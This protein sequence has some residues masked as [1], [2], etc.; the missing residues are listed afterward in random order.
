MRSNK[1]TAALIAAAASLTLSFAAASAASARVPHL[2]AN[3][4]RA[5]GCRVTLDFAYRVIEANQPATAVGN[6]ICANPSEETG[7][8]V[9]LYQRA[10]NTAKTSTYTVAGTGTTE[11]GGA[12]SIE[13]KGVTT[14][15]IFYALAGGIASR[16]RPLGVTAEVKVEGPPEGVIFTGPLAR[17]HRKVTATFKGTVSPLDEGAHVILQRQNALNGNGWLSINRPAIVNGKGEYTIEHEFVIPGPANIRVLVRDPKVNLPS[18]SNVLSYEVS[19][20]EN[21]QF[22]IESKADPISYGQSVTIGGA[23]S[24][25]PV[26]TPVKLLARAANQNHFAVVAEGKTEDSTGTYTV[27]SQTPLVNTYYKAEAAGKHSTILFEGVK[28]VLTAALLPGTSVSKGTELTFSG[29]VKPGV[30]KHIV[31]LEREDASHTAFNVVET[32]EVHEPNAE[33]PEYWYS[34]KYTPELVG[35]SKFRVKIP[36]DPQNG[37]TESETFTVTVTTAPASAIKPLGT[38]TLPSEGQV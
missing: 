25:V 26:G 16:H 10:A 35:T 23:V 6:L 15:S 1:L 22:T 3:G 34:L 14:D 18:A 32:G 19:Q 28:Y 2:H 24:S 7:Q 13:V 4:T 11:A 12:Y 37:S 31:Y 38:P 27:A 5:H 9:T 33:H 30:A 21:P 17:H 8:T 36:G 29:T 20:R